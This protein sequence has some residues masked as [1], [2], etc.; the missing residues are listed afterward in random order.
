M[1]FNKKYL[2]NFGFLWISF[3]AHALEPFDAHYD[4]YLG[5]MYIGDSQVSLKQ[6]GEFYTLT[7][8][9]ETKGLAALLY[10]TK[11]TETSE[12][13]LD[14]G[15]ISQRYTYQETGKKNESYQLDLSDAERDYDLLNLAYAVGYDWQRLTGLKNEYIIERKGHVDTIRFQTQE[16]GNGLIEAHW[17]HPDMTYKVVIDPNSSALAVQIQFAK[18]NRTLRTLKLRRD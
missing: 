3:S 18:K 11:T 9:A 7:R 12:F 1:L 15:L 17:Q 4:V 6:D 2:L 16:L 5:S 13:T 10:N 14:N 8:T